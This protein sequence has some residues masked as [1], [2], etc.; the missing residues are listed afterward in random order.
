MNWFRSSHSMFCRCSY[1][2]RLALQAGAIEPAIKPRRTVTRISS[3]LRALR[4]FVFSWLLL[5][6]EDLHDRHR[7]R[8]RV[9]EAVLR[10]AL[11][12]LRLP[13][14]HLCRLLRRALELHAG[15][16]RYEEVIL[17]VVVRVDIAHSA[18]RHVDAQHANLVAVDELRIAHAGA[19]GCR[20]RVQ[21]ERAGG[22]RR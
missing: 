10:A 1:G 11:D 18:W 20:D 5:F 13:R 16:S 2:G 3:C 6:D 22:T 8:A 9:L 12:K 17:H 21:H 19:R 14:G 15:S 7:G 4:V